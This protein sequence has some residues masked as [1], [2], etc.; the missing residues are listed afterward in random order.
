MYRKANVKVD[1]SKRHH[2]AF[3]QLKPCLQNDVFNTKHEF[4]S[5]LTR[6]KTSLGMAGML[7]CGGWIIEAMLLYIH[8]R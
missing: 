8:T 3:H 7:K 6:H 4:S 5:S 2:K 1:N